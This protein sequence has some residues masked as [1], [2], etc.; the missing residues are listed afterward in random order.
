MTSEL[1][2]HDAIKYRELTLKRSSIKGQITK[3]KNYISRLES[4]QLSSLEL[5]ELSLKLNKFEGLSSKFDDL[6]NEIE[7][8]NHKNLDSEIDERDNIE[9]DFI[10]CIATAKNLIEDANIQSEVLRKSSAFSCNHHHNSDPIGFKLPRI[11]VSKFDGAYFRWLEFRD[12][13][14]DLIHNNERISDI[15]KF[16]YLTSYLEGDA[17]RIISNLEVSSSNYK[18]AWSLLC[19]RYDK[20]RLLINYHLSELLN[21]KPITSES[22]RSLRFLADHVTKNLRALANLGR[23]TDKWDDIIVFMMSSKLDSNSLMKWEELYSLFLI[24]MMM[25]QL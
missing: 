21:M 1:D 12:T 5:V 20:R 10:T 3:F 4:V 25:F 11:E 7:V 22:E 13:F 16:H 8:L 2:K 14:R 9:Q 19:E 17:A 18:E 15:H 6:Q 23:P 24:Q